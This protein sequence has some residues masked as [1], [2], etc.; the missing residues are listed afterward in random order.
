VLHAAARLIHTARRVELRI[1]R[2]WRWAQ[3]IASGFHRLGA[4]FG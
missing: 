1:D 2:T 3:P 4:A